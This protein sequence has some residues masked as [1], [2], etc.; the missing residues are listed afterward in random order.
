MAKAVYEINGQDFSTLEEFYDVIE[1][2][3]IPGV[4]WGRNLNALNDIFRGGF[5][6]PNGQG[7]RITNCAEYHRFA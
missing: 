6:T 1:R 4:K 7:E 3:L 2:E 5:G